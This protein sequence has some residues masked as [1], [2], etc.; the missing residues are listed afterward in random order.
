MLLL[1]LLD[2]PFSP[3]HGKASSKRWEGRF[4]R[5][6]GILRATD[7][8]LY[9]YLF[10]YLSSANSRN[11][12]LTSLNNPVWSREE[13]LKRVSCESIEC[14]LH[15]YRIQMIKNVENWSWNFKEGL[16]PEL[17]SYSFSFFCTVIWGKMPHMGKKHGSGSA[18]VMAISLFNLLDPNWHTGSGFTGSLLGV[19]WGFGIFPLKTMAEL[20]VLTPVISWKSKPPFTVRVGS[21]YHL[22]FFVVFLFS[23]SLACFW[24]ICHRAQCC[25]LPLGITQS[26]CL[27]FL[28]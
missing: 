1:L 8:V 12:K 11:C 4:L 14:L 5:L 7:G 25:L 6:K 20:L 9:I 15:L 21:M 13:T 3:N 24:P 17:L 18:A 2:S 19:Y 28:T 26:C 10:S 27:L 16:G 23:H 22:V